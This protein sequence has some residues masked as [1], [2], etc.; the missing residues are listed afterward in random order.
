MELIEVTRAIDF[1]K[2]DK[3]EQ[4]EAAIRILKEK[5]RTRFFVDNPGRV[6][7]F[8]MPEDAMNAYFLL[9]MGEMRPLFS[10]K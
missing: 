7:R 5:N 10:K 2:D 4:K 6:I 1:A 3:D 8:A 9:V